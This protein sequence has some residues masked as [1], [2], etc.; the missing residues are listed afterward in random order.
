MSAASYK[1]P[2]RSIRI[3]GEKPGVGQRIL[4]AA[5]RS[6]L[7][8]T[9]EVIPG[10]TAS[11]TR[12]STGCVSNPPHQADGGPAAHFGPRDEAVTPRRNPALGAVQR[13]CRGFKHLDLKAARVVAPRSRKPMK[14][15]PKGRTVDTPLCLGFLL[16]PAFRVVIASDSLDVQSASRVR[17][18]YY[19]QSLRRGIDDRVRR[20]YLERDEEVNILTGRPP[21][22]GTLWCMLSSRPHSN[23]HLGARLHDYEP[24]STGCPCLFARSSVAAGSL[25]LRRGHGQYPLKAPDPRRCQHPQGVATRCHETP[26]LDAAPPSGTRPAPFTALAWDGAP[27][28]SAL[29]IRRIPRCAWHETLLRAGNSRGDRAYFPRVRLVPASKKDAGRRPT[30][31][32]P[33]R[34]SR[35]RTDLLPRRQGSATRSRP[36]RGERGRRSTGGAAGRSASPGESGPSSPWPRLARFGRVMTPVRDASTVTVAP[37]LLLMVVVTAY[38]LETVSPWSG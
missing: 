37:S 29:A 22:A 11:S 24:H 34:L 36:N 3:G 1:P 6:L 21:A 27:S 12:A 20:R 13:G 23:P 19:K 15:V 10:T 32:H 8:W 7:I 16:V 17:E 30:K 5:D 25:N 26:P 14:P 35:P 9:S 33:L 4:E 2:G 28:P 38:A 18:Y 31:V